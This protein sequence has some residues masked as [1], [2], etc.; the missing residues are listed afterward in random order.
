MS[1]SND[2]VFRRVSKGDN[3]AG[4]V[5]H[6]LWLVTI[7]RVIPPLTCSECL[8]FSQI[9]IF[10]SRT[11]LGRR[12][13][14]PSNDLNFV[15]IRETNWCLSS[16]CLLWKPALYCSYSLTRHYSMK[17][18]NLKWIFILYTDIVDTGASSV[19]VLPI[20]IQGSRNCTKLHTTAAR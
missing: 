13:L 14:K 18:F 12:V 10:C 11:R 19:P 5:G 2:W 16:H 8:N 4:S 15:V 1:V 3:V 7:A 6:D 9:M 17:S 20:H